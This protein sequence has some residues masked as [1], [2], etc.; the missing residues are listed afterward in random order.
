MLTLYPRITIATDFDEN[1][2]SRSSFLVSNDGYLPTYTVRV[3]C[4]LGELSMSNSPQLYGMPPNGK[5]GELGPAFDTDKLPIR[6]LYPGAKE[7]VP[8]TICSP[9]RFD[10]HA[11]L[12]TAHI[13]LSVQ[14]RPL[15]WPRKRYVTQEFY[16]QREEN[17][18]YVWYSVP[19]P[20]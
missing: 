13:A 16:A 17:G 18:V 4:I 12:Q 10:P 19:Y 3:F 8:W 14:Y 5:E 15:L 11:V 1:D 6:T 9:F 7:T 2:P 20:K